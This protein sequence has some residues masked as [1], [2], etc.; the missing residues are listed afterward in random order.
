V[1]L[2]ET[3]RHW[4]AQAEKSL[5]QARSA[6]NQILRARKSLRRL[7]LGDIGASEIEEVDIATAT[8]LSDLED[9][10]VELGVVIEPI[11]QVSVEDILDR[12]LQRRRPFDESGR[13]FRDVLVW[14]SLKAVLENLAVGQAAYF[15]TDN[16][17]D[18]CEGATLH[19][20]LMSE[21]DSFPVKPIH[22]RAIKDLFNIPA[23]SL[24]LESLEFD[25]DS[26]SIAE[27]IR[28]AVSFAAEQ[29]TGETIEPHDEFRSSLHLEALGLPRELDEPTICSVDV[30]PE[31][32]SYE[33]YETY[34]G[35]TLLVRATIS[36]VIEVEAFVYQSDYYRIESEVRLIESDC[37]WNDHMSL[38]GK[39]VEAELTYQLRMESD[40]ER[41]EE[42]D[43]ESIEP[44]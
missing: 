7:G 30:M 42:V 24:L 3:A 17:K 5:E 31:T 26:I 8:Y 28:N 20:S 9:R 23:V 4:Q 41:V 10:L 36:A 37:A 6:Q 12:D 16:I 44:L 34:E 1:V 35:G 13:G 27:L 19:P 40:G 15:V 32:A 43:L 18:Y 21:I 29:L 38:V 25:F 14:H 22:V 2:L 33:I 39:S 11:P